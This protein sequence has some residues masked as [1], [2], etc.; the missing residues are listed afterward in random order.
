MFLNRINLIGQLFVLVAETLQMRIKTLILPHV[1]HWIGS[2][3]STRIKISPFCHHKRS[4]N[5]FMTTPG[6]SPLPPPLTQP[7]QQNQIKGKT[8][9]LMALGVKIKASMVFKTFRVQKFR[10]D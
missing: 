2:P 10:N 3:C 4:T 1:Y 6:K 9:P 5:I 7:Y 8:R